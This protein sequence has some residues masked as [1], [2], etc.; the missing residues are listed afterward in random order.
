MRR[1][2][3]LCEDC[4]A[5]AP[6]DR[7]VY[8]TVELHSIEFENGILAFEFSAPVAGEAVVQLSRSPSGPFIAGGKPADF[9]W[10]A[11][12]SAVRLPI[13][14]GKGVLYRVRVG[15]ENTEDAAVALAAA[16]RRTTPG[17]EAFVVRLN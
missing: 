4:E 2:T 9:E 1:F 11:K 14:A 17:L 7:L 8:S 16:L 12:S 6:G 3:R 13:P 5:F 15:H 10:D